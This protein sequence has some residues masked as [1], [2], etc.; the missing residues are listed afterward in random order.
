M[1]LFVRKT[2]SKRNQTPHY[3]KKIG[4]KV[5][6]MITSMNRTLDSQARKGNLTEEEVIKNYEK[7]AN[8]VGE[9]ISL[10]GHI[11]HTNPQLILNLLTGTTA[12]ITPEMLSTNEF[13]YHSVLGQQASPLPPVADNT[14]E[15]EDDNEEN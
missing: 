9:M 8:I 1:K 5:S 7:I 4:K 6:E 12:K 14:R 2:K 10:G 3:S 11:E 15:E 13:C